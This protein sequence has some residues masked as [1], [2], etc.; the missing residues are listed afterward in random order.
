MIRQKY[1]IVHGLV[2]T[3]LESWRIH[4]SFACCE[5]SEGLFTRDEASEL[6]AE[7]CA[8]VHRNEDVQ[9]DLL[10]DVNDGRW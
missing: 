5:R 8:Q 6:L 1:G 4:E 3:F 2:Y 10:L 9:A 7:Y